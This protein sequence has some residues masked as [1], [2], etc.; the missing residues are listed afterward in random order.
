MSK[1]NIV[2][3]I[4]QPDNLIN[5]LK[6]MTI[7]EGDCWIYTGGSV[8]DSGYRRVQIAGKYI[9]VHRLSAAIF[10]GLNLRDFRQQANHKVECKNKTCW[11]PEHIYVGTQGQNVKDYL[12]GKDRKQY[13]P[14]GH[15]KH[16]SFSNNVMICREC[17]N[18][19]ARARRRKGMTS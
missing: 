16:L 7:Y 8:H 10:H 18:A 17:I 1:L 14:K 6:K 11:N 19:A 4:S 3:D 15:L 2:M 12:S 5:Y 13:C 9:G